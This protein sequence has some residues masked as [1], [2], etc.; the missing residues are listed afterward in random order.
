[1]RGSR[2]G[3]LLVLA[4]LVAAPLNT[5]AA[6]T[7]DEGEPAPAISL[8]EA[9]AEDAAAYAMEFGVSVPEAIQRLRA[10]QELGRI[11]AAVGA[12]A[13]TRFA[14]SWI[15][16]EPDYR[17]VIRFTGSVEPRGLSELIVDSPLPI[18]VL[19]E[20]PR[21]QTEL[22][23]A[24]ERLSARGDPDLA[25][26]GMEVDVVS[27]SITLL[28]PT[29]LSDEKTDFLAQVAEAPVVVRVVPGETLLHTYGGH[30]LHRQSDSAP[31]CTTA[32]SIRNVVTLVTG[33]LTAG[34]CA[35]ELYYVESP[36]IKYNITRMGERWDAD[37]DWQWH[38]TSHVEYSQF[39]SGSSYRN[40]NDTE[41]RLEMVGDYVCHFGITTGYSCGVIQT[42][43]YQSVGCNGVACDPV[44]VRVEGSNLE[45]AGGDSG[46]PWFN[47]NTAYGLL[48]SGASSG[49]GPGQCAFATFN[50]IGA[51]QG[52]NNNLE[53]MLAP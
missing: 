26:M 31:V 29:P 42:I 45:C 16:H 24:L 48:H 15:Q 50:S 40:V 28:G 30:P 5:S 7:T 43:H 22:L 37:Q 9:V 23:A 32:F 1:M 17:G 51:I 10:Q 4:V 34:H 53:L 3:R 44:W 39:W 36:A 38:T 21:S 2:I 14:G 41:P 20:A 13:P 33:V 35:N 27:S 49:T 46:G 6:S 52:P 11:L 12:L 47:A 8:E 18:D 25:M 19:L